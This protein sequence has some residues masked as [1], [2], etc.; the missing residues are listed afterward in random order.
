MKF[1]KSSICLIM[2]LSLVACNSYSSNT[3]SAEETSGQTVEAVEPFYIYCNDEVTKGIVN[4]FVVEH[5]E[6]AEKIQLVGMEEEDYAS[7]LATGLE[8][9]SAENYPDLVVLSRDLKDV[10]LEND[11]LLSIEQ[12][13]IKEEELSDMYDYMIQFGTDSEGTIK[14]LSWADAA[15]VFVYRVSLAEKYLEITT[16]E[17]M[18]DAIATWVDFAESANILAAKS[19]DK[20]RMIPELD[21]VKKLLYYGNNASWY[22]E[23]SEDF[24]ISDFLMEGIMAYEELEE[25]LAWDYKVESEEWYQAMADSTTLGFL[26]SSYFVETILAKNC[27]ETAGDWAICRAPSSYELDGVWVAATKDCA[28]RDLAEELLRYMTMEEGVLE[29]IAATRYI[30]VNNTTLMETLSAEE[31]VASPVLMENG[32]LFYYLEEASIPNKE[33]ADIND[34]FWTE[35]ESY[36]AE[37]LNLE[38][39]LVQ[40]EE[41]V[42]DLK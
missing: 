6:Y 14:A 42:K 13:G 9:A 19:N 34:L 16:Q 17:A 33:E 5:K 30:A 15:S 1:W 3:E 29:D 18:E 35:A 26:G 32:M 8:D 31:G 38:Q 24:V 40:I 25:N 12:L 7:F 28:D 2:S 22:P 4:S 37:K 39:F 21:S 23:D 36:W 20:I 27:G 11:K 10:Y 41:K